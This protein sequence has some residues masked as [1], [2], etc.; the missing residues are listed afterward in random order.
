M[1]N[2]PLLKYTRGKRKTDFNKQAYFIKKNNH[3]IKKTIDSNIVLGFTSQKL[4]KKITVDVQ[5]DFDEELNISHEED[6]LIEETLKIE[7]FSVP[8]KEKIL[9]ITPQLLQSNQRINYK[10]CIVRAFSKAKIDNSVF[11]VLN[12][13]SNKLQEY[14]NKIK[15]IEASEHI[16]N[17]EKFR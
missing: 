10:W 13:P 15:Q 9:N 3:R 1:L 6:Q 5:T 17:E 16:P 7:H 4:Q 14:F 2:L 8:K 11:E 12:N